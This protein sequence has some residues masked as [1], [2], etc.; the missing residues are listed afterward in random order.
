MPAFLWLFYSDSEEYVKA[1]R[2]P[3]S[4]HERGGD[5]PSYY[6]WHEREKAMPQNNLDL[7]TPQGK[8]GRYLRFKNH[9]AST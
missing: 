7:P 4:K 2:I 1:Q 3:T 6:E 8:R 5:P 9:L